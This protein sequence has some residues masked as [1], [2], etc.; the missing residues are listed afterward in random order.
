MKLVCR[1]THYKKGQVCCEHNDR[2]LARV[3]CDSVSPFGDRLTTLEIVF[4]R[5]VLAEFNTHRIF[6]RNSASSRAIPIQKMLQRVNEDPYVPER[7]TSN[8][9]GMQGEIITDPHLIAMARASWLTARDSAV[10]N[11][12]DLLSL[13][14]HKQTTNRLLE[15]FMWH[16]VIVTATEWANFLHLRCHETAHPA[17]QNTAKA[18]HA[19]LEANEPTEVEWGSWHLPY[20]GEAD[21]GEIYEAADRPGDPT[22]MA[23]L[24]L[25]KISCARCARVSYLTHEG[26]REIA[27]DLALH[28]KL[29]APGHMSPFEHAA[30][31][32]EKGLSFLGKRFHPDSNFRRPWVQYRKMIPWERDVHSDPER[33]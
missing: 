18:M 8:Q 14:I 15:P 4:P 33:A 5:I 13:G 16:T 30:Q 1:D 9:A 25:A 21:R 22:P 24:Q 17:I 2:I 29:I 7:W 32:L 6:S 20:I 31:C 23:E 11:V 10:A 19:V 12:E 26:K 3:V 28:D 27:K